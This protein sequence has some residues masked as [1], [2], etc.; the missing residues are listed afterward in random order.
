MCR[1]GVRQVAVANKFLQW[2]LTFMGPQCGANVFF[3]LFFK[4]HILLSKTPPPPP[5]NRAV[6]EI[7]GKNTVEL[8][9]PHMCI[10]CWKPKATNT[11]S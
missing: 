1:N 9:R 6:Y 5:P 4:N 8:H 11:H 3:V 7:I 2:H 10:A